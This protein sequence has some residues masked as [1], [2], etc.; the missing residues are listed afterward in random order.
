LKKITA[1]IIANTT[2][3]TIA[4]TIPGYN[5]NIASRI[6]QPAQDFGVA[7]PALR[8]TA[9]RLTANNRKTPASFR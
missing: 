8:L 1:N 9:L 3:D 2:A 6:Q 5:A 4:K 7:I